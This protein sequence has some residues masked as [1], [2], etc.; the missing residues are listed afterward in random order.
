[1]SFDTYQNTA[2]DMSEE[3]VF[4]DLPVADDYV[5]VVL[6]GSFPEQALRPGDRLIRSAPYDG[7]QHSAV[8]V[9]PRIETAAELV[10]RGVP[11]ESSA[12]GGYVE[13]LEDMAGNN[14]L[15]SVGRRL[16]DTAGRMLRGQQLLRP[17]GFGTEITGL[18]DYEDVYSDEI[19]EP[20]QPPSWQPAEQSVNQINWC[21]MRQTIAATARAE[22]ARW[23]APNG[24]KYLESNHPD[25]LAIL[26]SYWLTV[27]GFTTQAAATA[28]ATQSINNQIAWSAAF[29]CYVMHT[30]GIR[31][32]HGF[33]F[34]QRHLTYIVGALRNRERSDQN[35]PFWLVDEIEVQREADPKSGDLICF[36]RPVNGH[37]TTHSYTSLRNR[38]WSGGNQNR[39]VSG[40]SHA[41][42]VVGTTTHNGQRYVETIGGNENQS[43]RIRRIP[44][45]QWGGIPNPQAQH[46]FGMIKITRC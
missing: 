46:I 34:S 11:V 10:A 16:T 35:R 4:Q 14:G 5:P 45:D 31:Q 37:M 8:I 1:M 2:F 22:E 43:V 41:S 30:A 25:R 32:A 27:P 19:A 17:S 29:I 3:P 44:V 36:N 21:Q 28:R 40:S 38:Y 9:S 24:N 23:T 13:V 33:E 6:P 42:I 7:I 26:T 12:S 15:N 39:A 18:R 20:E